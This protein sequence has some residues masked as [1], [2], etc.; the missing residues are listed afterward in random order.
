[1]YEIKEQSKGTERGYVIVNEE[2]GRE[3]GSFR[4][5]EDALAKLRRLYSARVSRLRKSNA[6]RFGV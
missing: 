5:Y 3:V 4:F 6:R 2:T 1:M